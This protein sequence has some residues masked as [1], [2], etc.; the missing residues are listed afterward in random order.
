MWLL[1]TNHC[2]WGWSHGPIPGQSQRWADSS[3]TTWKDG[4]EGGESPQGEIG[5][6]HPE[7]ESQ[8]APPRW[9][10]L[11]WTLIPPAFFRSQD[12]FWNPR[13][14]HDL[15]TT[16]LVPFHKT[17]NEGPERESASP[18]VTQHTPL[19]NSQF[20]ES[21]CASLTDLLPTG[22]VASPLPGLA[23]RICQLSACLTKLMFYVSPPVCKLFKN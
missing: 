21:A 9:H 10:P 16:H 4:K 7:K 1:Q 5:A 18:K 20:L 8:Q 22:S 13:A 2:C 6:Q 15:K 12:V 17:K 23:E 3:R 19:S 14:L 11:R